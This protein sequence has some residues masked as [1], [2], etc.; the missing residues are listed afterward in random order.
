MKS[1]IDYEKLANELVDLYCETYGVKECISYLL[2]S[3]YTY[4]E[5]TNDFYFNENDVKSVMENA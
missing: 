5:L 1:M 4:E 2:K 3:G